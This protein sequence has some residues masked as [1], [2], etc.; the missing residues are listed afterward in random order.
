MNNTN[1]MTN[2]IYCDSTV[3]GIEIDPNYNVLHK[4]GKITKDP[5][6]MNIDDALL[7]KITV[8]PNPSKDDW[9]VTNLPDNTMLQLMDMNGRLLW[10]KECNDTTTVPAAKL[11]K[12]VYTLLVTVDNQSKFIRLIKY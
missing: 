11:I 10:Q 7:K 3:T 4:N 5:A 6:I 9:I 2:F 8:S 12:G 1:S